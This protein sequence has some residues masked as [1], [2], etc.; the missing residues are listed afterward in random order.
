MEHRMPDAEMAL[1]EVKGAMRALERGFD[2]AGWGS[3]EGNCADLSALFGIFADYLGAV[4]EQEER[5]DRE[6]RAKQAG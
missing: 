5:E 3:F 2:R 4:M 1:R 6:R